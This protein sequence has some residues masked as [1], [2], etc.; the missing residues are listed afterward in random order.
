MERVLDS[1]CREHAN[2]KLEYAILSVEI[3]TPSVDDRT[4]RPPP[5]HWNV[6]D[7]VFL[8]S[9]SSTTRSPG[10][11]VMMVAEAVRHVVTAE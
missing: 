3:S 10:E 7:H 9:T 11:V 8:T 2:P 6:V 5:T 1:G 4:I